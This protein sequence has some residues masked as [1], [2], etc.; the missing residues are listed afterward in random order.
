LP[1]SGRVACGHT[2]AISG[3]SGV[4]GLI[5]GCLRRYSPQTT[6]DQGS[7]GARG[8]GRGWCY[9]SERSGPPSADGLPVT[10]HGLPRKS[11]TKQHNHHL[12]DDAYTW[13]VTTRAKI[14]SRY[15]S[16]PYCDI[17]DITDRASRPEASFLAVR[18]ITP[19]A[20]MI[21][22]SRLLRRRCRRG[23]RSRGCGRLGLRLG[24]GRPNRGGR[25]T[26]GRDGWGGRR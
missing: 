11:R 17:T 24:L 6:H 4:P 1:V 5:M 10:L 23:G 13:P 18:R 26:R 8:D 25:G 14:R 20:A 2:G 16:L 9:W 15:A 7:T 12:Y 22:E 21:M 3:A 19:L